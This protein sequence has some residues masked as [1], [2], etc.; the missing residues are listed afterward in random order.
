MKAIKYTLLFLTTTLL[1]T[2][3]CRRDD[4][5][6][7]ACTD[8]S[9]PKCPN[10]DP[11]FGVEPPSA[12]FTIQE[13][14][15][16]GNRHEMTP[17]D[18][19]FLGAGN[20]FFSSSLKG[21]EYKHT[22]YLGSEVIHDAEFSRDHNVVTVEQRPYFITVSHVLEYPIDSACY[23]NATGKD[24]VSRTYRLIRNFNEFGTIGMFRGVFQN[25]LDSFDF[26]FQ[27]LNSDGDPAEVFS[28]G[29]SIIS[30]NFHNEGGSRNLAF[31]PR[32]SVLALTGSLG[33]PVGMM[34]LD[35]L[36]GTF[37][38]TYRYRYEDYE[39]SGR[40]ID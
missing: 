5:C 24:S 7:R 18:S 39:V 6:E 33:T 2:L 10:Y 36:T 34:Y 21:P 40:K 9:N 11:C 32:N 4:D 22:W 23:P 27:I 14:F 25:E 26:S 35:P 38:M 30:E 13:S 3:A 17:D 31:N 37:V 19:I 20:L 8:P 29:W 12:T 1:V 15:F 16:A 28:S